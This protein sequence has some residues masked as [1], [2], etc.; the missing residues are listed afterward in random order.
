MHA[1]SP[2]PRCPLTAH[3][4]AKDLAISAE[5]PRVEFDTK[6]LS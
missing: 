3:D 6:W 5:G 2:R 1:R 4:S